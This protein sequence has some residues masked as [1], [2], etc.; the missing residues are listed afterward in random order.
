MIQVLACID[1][2]WFSNRIICNRN[3][4]I[5]CR[6][7]A[8]TFNPQELERFGQLCRVFAEDLVPHLNKCLQSLFPPSQLA[9]ALGMST[10]ELLKMVSAV[11][12]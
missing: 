8:P 12:Q 3:I 4:L 2:F 11:V 7:E 10:V 9:Q 5:F 6:A 1:P